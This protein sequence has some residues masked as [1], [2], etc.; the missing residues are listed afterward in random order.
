MLHAMCVIIH[1]K[2]PSNPMSNVSN[3]EAL[4][5]PTF[6]PFYSLFYA[7]LTAPLVISLEFISQNIR[8]S[9]TH[10]HLCLDAAAAT[11]SHILRSAN[12]LLKTDSTFGPLHSHF[13]SFTISLFYSA[14]MHTMCVKM[15]IMEK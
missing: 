9:C 13:Y 7:I 5:F 4:F 6:S 14:T 1:L 3:S 15:K 2:F 8:F 12:L 10:T 11:A